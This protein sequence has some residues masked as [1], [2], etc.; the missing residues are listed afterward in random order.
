MPDSY[1]LHRYDS[2]HDKWYVL[3]KD[4]EVVTGSKN[5]YLDTD[6][7][8]G[9]TYKYRLVAKNNGGAKTNWVILEAITLP[10]RRAPR[11]P[12]AA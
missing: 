11:N 1:E 4:M 9:E 8:P 10:T 3:D 7:Y 2:Y 6:V 5:Y 12:F